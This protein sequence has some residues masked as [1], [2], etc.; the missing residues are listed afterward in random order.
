M[1]PAIFS[2][3]FQSPE[4]YYQNQYISSIFR[5]LR[6]GAFFLSMYASSIYLA[7]I[8]HHQGLIPTT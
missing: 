2:Q 3:F 1:V 7:L 4:D 5:M 8:T 6:F